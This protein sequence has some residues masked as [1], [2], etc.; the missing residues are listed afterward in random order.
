MPAG[1]FL[2]AQAE[3]GPFAALGIASF[4]PVDLRRDSP[5]YGFITSTPKP[6]WTDTDLV[7]YFQRALGL[8]IRFDTDVNGALMAERR[9][10][11]AQGMENA[12][13][14]TVGTGIGAGVMVDGRLV[15]GAMH[16][17]AG[18]MLVPRHPSDPFSGACPY[19]GACLEGLAAGPALQQRWQQSPQ[20][21]P[22][23]HPAWELQAHYL[24]IMCVNL[25]LV[26]SPQRIVL[27]GGVMEREALLPMVRRAYLA[28]INGYLG[29]QHAEMESFITGPGL[30]SMAGA[31]GA[32]AL[33]QLP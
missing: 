20:S 30:G 26:Y 5:T 18:H 10:G 17:E 8:P 12:I 22:D 21:M 13:Y 11:A 9:W 33:A 3:H 14:V 1:I 27:G 25:A 28:K 4:G 31:L 24:A 32:I 23:H 16:P 15:H 6:N 29:D 2:A 19:H 7:G